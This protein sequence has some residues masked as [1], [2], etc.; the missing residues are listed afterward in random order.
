MWKM[1]LRLLVGAIF[2]ALAAFL[3]NMVEQKSNNAQLVKFIEDTVRAANDPATGLKS[4]LGKRSWV[5][6]T[7]TDFARD[8]LGIEVSDS[9]L[10]TFI[11]LTVQ[12]V[13]RG[14]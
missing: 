11:E 8:G 5:K 1:V 2:E 9:M 10:N 4:D 3:D 12:K 7:V 13:K 6:H 14:S